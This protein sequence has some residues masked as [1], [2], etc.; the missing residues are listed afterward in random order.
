MTPE[1][2]AQELIKRYPIFDMKVPIDLK[3]VVFMIDFI[4]P[5]LNEDGK[6]HWTKVNEILK[7]HIN[8]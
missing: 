8:G 2:Q 1:Q 6:V 7:N 4:I 3:D 5:E